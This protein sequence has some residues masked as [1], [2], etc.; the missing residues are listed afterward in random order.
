MTYDGPPTL[1]HGPLSLA[2]APAK[3]GSAA[4]FS[5]LDRD[6]REIPVFR[7][8]PENAT[9]ALEH[10]T[11]PMVPYCNRI[12]GGAFT[13]RGREVR[14]AP[15][16]AGDPSPLHGDGW[17]AQWE[18]TRLEA[19]EAELRYVQEGGEWPWRYEARQSFALDQGGL[20]LVLS[21]TNLS[22]EPMP[23][24]LGHHPYFN[25]TP[26]TRIDVEVECAWTI[27]A[28]VLPVDKVPAEGRYDLRN[29]LV[30]GQGLDNGFGGFGGVARIE[31][32]SLPFRIEI[33]SDEARFFQL[34]SPSEGGIFVAEPVS[35]ANAALNEPEEK[36]EE[37]GLRVLAPGETMR[38]PMRIEVI[39]VQ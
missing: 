15:N 28:D 26:Q 11:F 24:G 21:C 27:D 9:G 18:V 16:M 30:C 13:F 35:H 19:S 31:D 2:L 38:L 36:W 37:L 29:R 33:R 4:S 14:I 22:D 17:L 5:Y 1:S 23:C 12:R 20:T 10:S 25:C 6:G 3:G 7:G 34:Y 32:P 8:T 39:P